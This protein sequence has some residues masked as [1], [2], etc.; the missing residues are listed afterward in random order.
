[1]GLTF[2]RLD[3]AGEFLSRTGTFLVAREAAHNL[4]LGVAA[5][6]RDMPHHFADAEAPGFGGVTDAADG[7]VAATMRTPPFNQ[8]IS[9]VD[10]PAAID[11]LAERLAADPLPGVTG[12]KEVAARFAERW[13]ELTGRRTR[14]ELSE[15]IFRLDRV[16]PPDRPAPGSWR[17]A[18]PRDRELVAAWLTAFA[19]EATPGQPT[20]GDPIEVADRWIARQ[21]RTHYLWEDEDRVVSLVGAGGATPNGVRIGPVYTPPGSRNRGYATSLTAAATQDQLD[22]GR[23]FVT[24]FTDLANPTSNRIYQAIGYV[25]VRDVDVIGFE[26]DA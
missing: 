20:P 17:L 13:S 22:S 14:I 18:Q 2:H 3:D 6:V 11:L 21:Y 24:L 7:V 1:M 4:M 26:P 23:R 8:V 9:E 12:P 25:A 5:Q 10:D 16:I 19:E 15:R